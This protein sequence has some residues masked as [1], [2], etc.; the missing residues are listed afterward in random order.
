MAGINHL[1][2]TGEG[3]I[4]DAS[5][6]QAIAHAEA[7]YFAYHTYEQRDSSRVS[8][9]GLAP[10]HFLPCRDGHVMIICPEE[11]QWRSLVDL[12]GNPVGA[13]RDERDSGVVLGRH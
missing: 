12:M 5:G 3:S 8:R 10:F 13:V 7:L 11:H 2:E 4:V 6:Q 9:P 1:R